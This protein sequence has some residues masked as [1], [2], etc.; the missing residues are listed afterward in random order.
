MGLAD[1]DFG[2]QRVGQ[3]LVLQRQYRTGLARALDRRTVEAAR[4]L[5]DYA[6]RTGSLV[7][8]IARFARLI[9]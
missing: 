6:V 5:P 9:A 2:L 4:R 7:V 1:P 3:R 8:G